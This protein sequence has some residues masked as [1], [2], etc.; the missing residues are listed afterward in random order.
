MKLRFRD[1]PRL[2]SRRRLLPSAACTG[3]RENLVRH[4][5]RRPL[6]RTM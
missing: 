4:P 5:L 2:G 6:L 3:G 1:A